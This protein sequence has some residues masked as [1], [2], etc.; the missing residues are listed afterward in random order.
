MAT[1]PTHLL[2]SQVSIDGDS[3]AEWH[4][5][6][7]GG[8]DTIYAGGEQLLTLVSC[9]RALLSSHTLTHS[10]SDEVPHSMAPLL[11]SHVFHIQ[12][13]TSSSPRPPASLLSIHTGLY[14]G[15]MVS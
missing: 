6:I 11:L 4:F 9:A 10:I 15:K 12:L 3:L 2:P 7:A 5:V 13:T 14:W 1:A 8:A